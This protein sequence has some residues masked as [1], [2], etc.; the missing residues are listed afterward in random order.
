MAR[1]HVV[2]PTPASST[3][4]NATLNAPSKQ[5]SLSLA[6]A[7]TTSERVQAV[8]QLLRPM[9][10]SDGGDVEFIEFTSEGIVKVRL[11]GACIGCPSSAITLK[12]GIER[13][14]RA[15]IPEVK[16]VEPVA[17]TKPDK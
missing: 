9:I 7:T 15:H 6:Q 4:L 11:L 1:L 2:P 14:L 5:P 8:L 10:Q 17:S 16:S 13:N 12:A 3:P